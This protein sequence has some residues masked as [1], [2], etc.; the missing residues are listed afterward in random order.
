MCAKETKPM[1]S[2]ASSKQVVSSDSD[3]KRLLCGTDFSPGARAAANAAAAMAQRLDAAVVLV[4]VVEQSL[5]TLLPAGMRK[6]FLA[7]SYER[8]AK[9][10]ERLRKLGAIV[11]ES[12]SVGRSEESLV[13]QACTS[14]AG[15]IVLSS[16]GSR[17]PERWLLGS[18]SERTAERAT[19]PT[20]VVRDAEPLVSWAR[21]EHTLRVFVAFNFTVTSEAAL[22]WAAQLASIGPCEFIVAYVDWPPKERARLGG[23]GPLPL[24]ENTPETQRLIERDLA[25]KIGEILGNAS[26][27]IRVEPG[28]GRADLRLAD[29]AREEKA[30]FIV[31]GSHQYHGFERWW[32]VSVS[33]GLLHH[34][35][36]S[37]AIVPTTTTKDQGANVVPIV[38]RVLVATDFSALG[39]RAVPYAYANLSAG[40]VVRM[41][42]VITPA[43]A[44]GGAGTTSASKRLAE[45]Q[46]QNLVTDSGQK[47]R[48]LI[49]REA[50]AR[51][52]VTE[53][54]VLSHREAGLAICQEAERFGADLICMGTHGRSGLTQTLLGSITNKVMTHSRRPLLVVRM[55]VP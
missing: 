41:I 5:L 35:P 26:A 9:E 29:L 20:V 22:R 15:F 19:V 53:V 8:L 2:K 55:P 43:E 50:E 54:E 39:D 10:A 32:N 48:E 45:K 36:I 30:D 44:T 18:V 27:K 16:L 13:E 6:S 3:R 51:G 17:A 12:F 49:P 11:E 37:V 25:A 40:S 31:I 23:T 52:I 7:S 1:S 42:H 4:H 14:D 28:W 38:R 46:H 47:L 21:G 24:A 34:A 33:R